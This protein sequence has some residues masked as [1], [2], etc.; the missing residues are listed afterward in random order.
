MRKIDSI[1][2][3]C[4]ANDNPKWGIKELEACHRDR[5][6]GGIGYHYWIA[7]DGSIYKTRALK[8][9]GAH[10][11]GHNK[12][13]IGICLHGLHNFSP[14][15]MSALPRLHYELSIPYK[16]KANRIFPHNAFSN[17]TCP[18][19]DLAPVMVALA[20]ILHKGV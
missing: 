19:F 12:H 13:S 17:K 10:C 20:D 7:F 11:F 2:I 5:G 4:D 6:F 14:R 1:I 16:I 8:D 15:Q 9:Q 3:H 18:N